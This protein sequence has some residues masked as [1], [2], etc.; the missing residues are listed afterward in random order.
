[1][2]Q[3]I[4][5]S[6]NPEGL[7]SAPVGSFFYRR[8][9]KYFLINGITEVE[10]QLFTVNKTTFFRRYYNPDFYKKCSVEYVADIETWIKADR[11]RGEKYGWQFVAYRPPTFVGETVVPPAPT[12]TETATPLPSPDPTVTPTLTETPTPSPTPTSESA[13]DPEFFAIGYGEGS[14][15]NFMKSADGINWTSRYVD[16]QGQLNNIEYGSGTLVATEGGYTDYEPDDPSGSFA[17]LHVSTD[18]GDTWTT[19]PYS[20]IFPSGSPLWDRTHLWADVVYSNG[21]FVVLSEQGAVVTSDDN[22]ASWTASNEVL[23]NSLHRAAVSGSVIV[24]LC[25]G[26]YS[27]SDNNNNYHVKVSTDGG[28]TWRMSAA[29]NIDSGSNF[30]ASWQGICVDEFGFSAVAPSVGG[31]M[32]SYDGIEWTNWT[33][34]SGSSYP[35]NG[36]D[37]ASGHAGY[38]IVQGNGSSVVWHIGESTNWIAVER[39]GSL[40]AEGQWKNITYGNG[41]YVAV[42]ARTDSG[43]AAMYSTD[44]IN[45]T[46]CNNATNQTQWVDVKHVDKPITGKYLLD[47]SM[48]STLTEVPVGTSSVYSPAGNLP[49]DGLVYIWK[50]EGTS[51]SGS[52]VC[53]NVRS[54]LGTVDVNSATSSMIDITDILARDTHGDGTSVIFTLVSD[55]SSS[56]YD[57]ISNVSLTN[58]V[59]QIRERGIRRIP[60]LT[61]GDQGSPRMLWVYA[62]DMSVS[63]KA[64]F[65]TGMEILDFENGGAVIHLV[66][67]YPQPIPY[68]ETSQDTLVRY[69]LDV[70]NLDTIGVISSSYG[71]AKYYPEDCSM[72]V[73]SWPTFHIWKISGSMSSGSLIS[74]NVRE[75]VGEINH[76]QHP[77]TSSIDITDIVMSANINQP[78]TALVFTAIGEYSSTSWDLM[79]SMSVENVTGSVGTISVRS[80]PYLTA[81]NSDQPKMVYIHDSGGNQIGDVGFAAGATFSDLY[82]GFAKFVLHNGYPVPPTYV[83]FSQNQMMPTPTPTPTP[84]PPPVNDSFDNAIEVFGESGSV[85]GTNVGSTSDPN[86]PSEITRSTTVW[87][88]WAPAVTGMANGT[89]TTVGSSFD[90][91]LYV[92]RLNGEP[93]QSNLTLIG[94]DDDDGVAGNTSAVNFTVVAGETYYFV[95]TGYSDDVGYIT[96]NYSVVPLPTPTPTS[97]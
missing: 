11:S 12:P 67:N 57:L 73:Y 85:Q 96:F 38:V 60:Y 62:D 88:K 8:G 42:N 27:G 49:S 58:I 66:P 41:V 65:A 70:S 91:Y 26:F 36:F 39:S 43:P 1:M 79:T 37:I 89:V 68:F 32:Y 76:L 83:E 48:Y 75:L 94:E 71:N 29:T 77:D 44:A 30:D 3:T 28:L 9:E 47:V 46:P 87:W 97:I 20:D 72:V 5:I 15:T 34:E 17:D 81:G 51:E 18:F 13:G 16:N 35:I 55:D 59:G 74:S 45:W 92:Y 90:T 23:G 53:N 4:R 84:P 40:P 10:E 33:D 63:G 50:V 86:D 25:S 24:Q 93:T 2:S 64:N 52:L 21:R 7:V 82:H 22:G 19:I 78:N 56:T 69:T 95:V 80:I 31:L 54:L 6:S 14:V 61:P